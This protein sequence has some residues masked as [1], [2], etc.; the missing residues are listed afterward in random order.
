MAQNWPSQPGARNEENLKYR[1][2]GKTG[3]EVAQPAGNSTA[4]ELE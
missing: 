2:N 1:G 4:R 3:R